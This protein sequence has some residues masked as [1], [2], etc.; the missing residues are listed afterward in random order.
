MEKHKYPP[1]QKKKEISAYLLQAYKH[2][3]LRRP[4]DSEP[5]K[6]VPWGPIMKPEAKAS[7]T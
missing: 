7:Y 3:S 2:A 1:P 6:L 4:Q 5:K